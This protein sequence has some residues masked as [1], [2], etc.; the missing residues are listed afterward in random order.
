MPL[1]TSTGT[2]VHALELS[3]SRALAVLI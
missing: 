1:G 3:L 2:P